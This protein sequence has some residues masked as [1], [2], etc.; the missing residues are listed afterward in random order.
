MNGKPLYRYARQGLTPEIKQRQINIHSLSIN[1]HSPS[2]LKLSIHCSKGTYI[3]S[4]VH[5]IG[6][7]LGCGACISAL[8]RTQL[9]HFSIKDAFLLDDLL[10]L[11]AIQLEQKIQPLS[12]CLPDYK[13]IDIALE[14]AFTIFQGKPLQINQPHGQYLFYINQKPIALGSISNNCV[15]IQKRLFMAW[16][17][18]TYA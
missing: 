17:K 16:F 2:E 8:K 12:A 15:H 5:D 11:S 6:Q 7:K 1:H 10:S 3:R 9:A 13:S 14:D 18:D 4:L